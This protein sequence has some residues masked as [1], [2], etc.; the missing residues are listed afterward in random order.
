MKTRSIVISATLAMVAFGST[1]CERSPRERL[2]GR[3]KG[4]TL[5]SAHPA[6]GRAEGWVKGTSLE[7]SGNKVTV[8]LPTESP[9][10][11]T[12]KVAKIEGNKMS[13]LFKRP[14]GGEDLAQFRFSDDG[15]LV[16]EMGQGEMVLVRTEL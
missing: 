10:S 15:K 2:Q 3:W 7:F 6:K 9:R 13:V 14:E 11:G 12:F 5:E 8:S 16:W 1:G 4:V